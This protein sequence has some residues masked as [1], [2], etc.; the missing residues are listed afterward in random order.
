M[1]TVCFFRG[2]FEIN[3]QPVQYGFERTT[4]KNGK[5]EEEERKTKHITIYLQSFKI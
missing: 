5:E 4:E 3:F 2:N 1:C